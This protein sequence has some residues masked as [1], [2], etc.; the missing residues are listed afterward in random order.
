MTNLEKY[1]ALKKPLCP[2][3]PK[4]WYYKCMR[5][6]MTSVGNLS[7]GIKIGNTYGY[8]SGVMLDYVYKNEPNGKFFIGKIID[9]FYLNS[10]GWRG[11]RNRKVLIENMLES[12]VK[13]QLESKE[14]LDY[15]DMACGGGEYDVTTIKK[16]GKERFCATLRDYK[17]E[18]I[19]KAEQNALRHEI[20]NITYE[21]ANAFD[22]KNYNQKWDLIV[23]SGFWEIIEDDN[24]VKNCL[25]NS[26]K[27]LNDG[28]SFIFTIQP[29]HPQLEFIGRVLH[30]N[31]GEMWTMRLRDL[32]LFKT[33]MSEAGLELIESKLEEYEIFGVVHARKIG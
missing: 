22:E 18:N 2:F 7:D 28:S 9:K 23:S 30:S 20:D 26:A 33:W 11:I 14:R 6:L 5:A 21:Q 19:Q 16:F 1:E 3:N 27:A 24:L 4:N 17:N 32:K 10:I 15:L 8:D 31:T 29:N 13:E 12:V 25:I